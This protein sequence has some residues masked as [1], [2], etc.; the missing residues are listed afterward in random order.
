MASFRVKDTLGRVYPSRSKRLAPDF[1]FQEQ[2]YRADGENIRLPSGEFTITCGRGPEYI[3]ET[4]T[5]AMTNATT[6][7]LEFR[8]RRWIDP[9][10]R[11]W[12]SGDH[13][14][15]AAGCASAKSAHPYLRTSVQSVAKGHRLR[16]PMRTATTC[17]HLARET[18][19]TTF[20]KVRI[21]RPDLAT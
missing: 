5:V 6:S 4:R 2:I 11:G 10:A 16:A 7:A 17:H 18:S 12:Y 19:I 20:A 9:A 3:P 14:I 1:F 15:H 8:L 21:D 13:H